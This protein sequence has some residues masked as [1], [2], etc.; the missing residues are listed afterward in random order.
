MAAQSVHVK[1]LIDDDPA[2]P[3]GA[4]RNG[5]MASS[6]AE[7]VA[8]LDDDD[9]LDPHHI[10]TLLEGE[11]D[12]IVPH[13]RFI[14]PPLPLG[15]Y[16]RPYDRK[17]LREHGIFPITVLARREAVLDAGGFGEGR[18]EDWDLWNVMADAG[19]SFEV[20]PLITWTYRTNGPG[21]SRPKPSVVLKTKSIVA[22]SMPAIYARVRSKP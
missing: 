19:A 15:F 4:K 12:V 17:D 18:Y 8:F 9:L 6:S 16:N 3:V 20:I 14:G 5:L 21:R 11:A 2:T 22:R 13:C 1:H 7:W 10:A